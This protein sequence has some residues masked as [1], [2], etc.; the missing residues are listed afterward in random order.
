MNQAKVMEVLRRIEWGREG[1]R[2]PDCWWQRG[3]G[4]AEGCELA[5]LL[6]GAKEGGLDETVEDVRKLMRR[7]MAA[8]DELS[9]EEQDKV[10]LASL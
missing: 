4:H 3:G 2:C 8:L 6:N 5:A 9:P 10:L 1:E 7:A